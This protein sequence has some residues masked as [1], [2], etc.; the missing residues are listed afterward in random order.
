MRI[1][2]KQRLQ[3]ALYKKSRHNEELVLWLFK[4][5][6]ALK[7][8]DVFDY[9]SYAGMP[10]KLFNRLSS[11]DVDRI[12]DMWT[13]VVTARTPVALAAALDMT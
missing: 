8:V 6:K 12:Q 11:T 1:R 5:R 10:R 9:P 4:N 2:D 7:D 3:R 13:A